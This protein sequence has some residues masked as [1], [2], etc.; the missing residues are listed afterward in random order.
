MKSKRKLDE[1]NSLGDGT[2]EYS[3]RLAEISLKYKTEIP[4]DDMPKV[5]NPREAVEVLRSIWDQ[6]TIQLKEEFY[7]LLLN[8]AKRCLGWSKV[9][10]GG[11]SATVV[12][13]ATVF[14]VA[15]LTNACSVILAHNH[16]SGN[17]NASKADINL[18]QRIIDVGKLLGINVE[19]HIILTDS[20]YCSFKGKGKI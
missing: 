1:L 19:D 4:T 14:Q 5:S 15:L 13:P 18:T 6:D 3:S 8:N 16:P 2:L 12:D 20:S 17:L 7:V 9:S 11:G 10:S